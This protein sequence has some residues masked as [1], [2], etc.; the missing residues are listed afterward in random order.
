MTEEILIRFINNTCTDE[1]LVAV[2][3]WLDESD[4]NAA[5]LFE[6]E[7]IVM[8]AGSSRDNT[9][10]RNRVFADIQQRI[11][12]DERQKRKRRRFSIYKWTSAAAAVV[13]I[14]FA[15]VFLFRQFNVDM[16]IVDAIAE[17]KTV[18]L[19]DGTIVY[20]NKNSQLVYPEKFASTRDVKLT[21]EG[22]FKVAHDKEHPFVVNGEYISVTVLGTEFNFNSNAGGS[23]NV[24]LMEGSV[25]VSSANG[26]DG[27]VLVP[28]QK[29]EYNISTGNITVCETKPAIDAAWHDRIIPFKKADIQEI[30]TALEQLYNVRVTLDKID[31]S[32]TYTGST[33]YYDNIDSTLVQLS[34]TLPIEFKHDE[35]VIIISAKL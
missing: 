17:N 4:D 3:S 6:M 2:K 8:L 13:A 35:S 7:K 16:I 5:K 33:I 22:F 9:D 21:G 32:K 24:S 20:L 25:K 28:G 14:I 26:N 18:N 1:E 15:S 23:N 19:P 12:A 34:N 10:T 11:I 29:A 27:V 31:T 30:A